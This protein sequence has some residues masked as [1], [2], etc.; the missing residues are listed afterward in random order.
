MGRLELGLEWN[1]QSG[2]VRIW[3]LSGMVREGQK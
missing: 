3:L 2:R 1:G